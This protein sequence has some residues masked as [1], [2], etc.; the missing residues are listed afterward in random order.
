MNSHIVLHHGH[1]MIAVG[2]VSGRIG[3]LDLGD[4]DVCVAIGTITDVR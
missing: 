2:L 3:A 4:R 1:R